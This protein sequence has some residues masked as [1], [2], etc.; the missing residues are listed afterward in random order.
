MERL[1]GRVAGIDVSRDFLDVHIRVPGLDGE[2]KRNYKRFSTMTVGLGECGDWLVEHGVE[3][4]VMEA[5]GMYW[6][7]AYYA[8]E[9]RIANVWVLNAHHVKNVPGRKT[10]MADAEWLADVAAHGM[11]LASF[12]PPAPIRELRELTRFRS[13]VVQERSRAVCRIDKML[14]DAGIKV[15]S[16]ASCV[17]GVGTREMFEL[18]IAG[19]RDPS[20]LAACAK[21][22]MRSKIDELTKALAGNFG[23]HHAMVIK[24]ILQQVDL[25]D[26]QIDE[27]NQAIDVRLEPYRESEERIVTIPG[28]ANRVAQCVI[29]EIGTDMSKF[30][31]PGHLSAWAGLAPAN[32][33]SG[34]KRRNAGS[35]KGDPHLKTILVQAAWAAVRVEG[36]YY[37][38]MF[39]RIRA[40]RGPNV[41]IVAVARKLIEAVW[42]VLTN[43]IDHKDLGAD[44]QER[45]HNPEI[46]I[47]RLAARIEAFGMKVS[48]EPATA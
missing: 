32:K 45:R 42:H 36:S 20:K 10:D 5:T 24:S 13:T 11:V 8:L 12:I 35:R 25:F 17:L 9:S 37:G 7:A 6:R 4:A 28:V 2:I 19:Q 33:E 39:R 16:V 27:L 46:Q 48:I 40:R 41:A 15:T 1:Y 44:Y 43:Q 21:G 29:S 3:L 18:L 22:R 26:T 34:G 47:R 23:D 38:S 31:T 14:Q 30:K